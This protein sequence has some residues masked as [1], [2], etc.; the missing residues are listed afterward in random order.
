M[1]NPAHGE[2]FEA[3]RKEVLA[4]LYAQRGSFVLIDPERI[5]GGI[6]PAAPEAALKN[7]AQDT[8][9]W[10]KRHGYVEGR[11]MTGH[12]QGQWNLCITP[13]GLVEYEKL[14]AAKPSA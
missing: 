14:A 3:C 8:V 5:V 10:L 7:S 12:M 11:S 2:I 9:K 1:A 6:F 4:R 13:R